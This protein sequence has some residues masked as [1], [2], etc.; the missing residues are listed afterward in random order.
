MGI[1]LNPGNERFE[2]AVNSQIYVDKTFDI[3]NYP[4]NINYADMSGNTTEEKTR[5]L[6]NWEY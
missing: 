5:L 1:Y 3:E 2:E 4:T 6:E